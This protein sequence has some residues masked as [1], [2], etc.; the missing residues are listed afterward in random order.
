MRH[1]KVLLIPLALCA[2]VGCGGAVNSG[3]RVLVSKFLY[4]SGMMPPQ[5]YDVVVFKYPM[6]PVERGTPKNYIKR[7]LGLPGEIIAIFFG[8][9]YRY[10]PDQ[11]PP[12]DTADINANDLWKPENVLDTEDYHYR[13]QGEDKE[14]RNAEEFAFLK[15]PQNEA[16]INA[17]RRKGQAFIRDAWDA[18]KFKILR[19]PLDTMMA[20]R[21]IVYDNDQQAKDLKGV[22]PPRWQT[23]GSTSAWKADDATGF[24]ATPGGDEP[25][26]LRYQHI[27]RP[28]EWPPYIP[29]DAKLDHDRAEF[30]RK[31]LEMIEKKGVLMTSPNDQKAIV[32]KDLKPQ[33]ILDVMGY[34]SYEVPSR[35]FGSTNPSNWVGDLMLECKLTV[36]A[37]KGECWLE[38]SKGIDRFQAR[39]NLEKGTCSLF[40]LTKG[41]APALLAEQ[42]TRITATGSYK[43]RFANIDE[44]LTLWVNDDLP[45]GD[46]HNYSSPAKYG[47]DDATPD[48]NDLQPASI[49]SKG[50]AVQVHNL[51]LWRDTYY[52]LA[53]RSTHSS[54]AFRAIYVHPG[55]YLCLGDN[56]PESSD[57]RYWG[58]VPERLMLGRALVVYFPF[59]RINVIK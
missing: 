53:T 18:K 47:P 44:R 52:T 58:L 13:D 3:D 54:D 32:L 35:P 7:L 15:D 38:L 4:D 42:P 16:I 40:R 29:K 27:Q 19:K 21:R 57:S 12:F 41:E 26:W 34:N 9:L 51:K 37:A 2:L 31:Q 24:V 20:L 36:T 55:H 8:R 33:L 14:E 17:R 59:E 25:Q 11:P 49:A 46:G 56:S 1:L 10:S 23:W 43:L 48:G 5:R 39:I 22:L 50:A 28:V 6:R 45:F 30:R